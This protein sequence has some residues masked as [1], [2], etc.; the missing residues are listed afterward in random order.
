MW[1]PLG[2]YDAEDILAEARG[3]MFHVLRVTCSAFGSLVLGCIC[4]GLTM[5]FV[6]FA[7]EHAPRAPSRPSPKVLPRHMTLFESSETGM[8]SGRGR[9]LAGPLR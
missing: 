8:C 5:S 4:G 9:S 3:I 2:L 7:C 6:R 1:L